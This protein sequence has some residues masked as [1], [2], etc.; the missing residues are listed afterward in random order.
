MLC[1]M[2][3]TFCGYYRTCSKGG[4]CHRALTEQVKESA[5][6]AEL[7]ICV[8]ME[9]PGCYKSMEQEADHD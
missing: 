9:R 7:N 2:D 6:K 4:S 5:K 3:K 1:Y 8:F